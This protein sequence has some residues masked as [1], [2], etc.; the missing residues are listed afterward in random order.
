M[1][2][3]NVKLDVESHDEIPL[4]IDWKGFP[5]INLDDK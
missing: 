3:I 1:Y 4:Y 2:I 5:A